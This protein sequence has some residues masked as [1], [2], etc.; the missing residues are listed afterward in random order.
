MTTLTENL[1]SRLKQG[2]SMYKPPFG[3]DV[4][5]EGNL[6]PMED[7]LEMLEEIKEML[8]VKALSL[9]EAALWLSMKSSRTISYEGLRKRL[10]RPVRLEDGSE[11]D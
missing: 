4:T 9:R 10:L 2:A 6:I 1:K 8:E 7:D 11:S 3:Y 5:E